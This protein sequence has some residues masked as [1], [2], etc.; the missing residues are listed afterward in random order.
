MGKLFLSML[1]TNKYEEAYYIYEGKKYG[2]VHFVQVATVSMNCSHWK[3][4]DR[5]IVFTTNEAKVKNWEDNGNQ[6]KGLK[7]FLEELNIKPSIQNIDIPNGESEDEIWQIFDAMYGAIKDKDEVVFDITHSFRSIPMLAMVVLN[8]AKVVKDVSIEGIYY[9]AFEKL[10]NLNTVRAKPLDERL[11]PIFNLTPF[12]ELLDWSL[13]LD[14]FMKTGDARAISNLAERT[15]RARLKKTAGE[16]HEARKTR[17]LAN[18]LKVF[19]ETMATCRGREIGQAA[20]NLKKAVDE[21]LS[22]ENI[23]APYIP[24]LKNLKDKLKGFAG[25]DIVVDGFQAALWCYEHNLIQQAYTILRETIL[26]KV[27]RDLGFNPED[28]SLRE[29]LSDALN[30]YGLRVVGKSNKEVEY[31]SEIDMLFEYLSYKKDLAVKY[32]DLAKY[33]NDID[34]A[35]M[36]RNVART[37]SIINNLSEFLRYFTK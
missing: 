16:D 23:K 14:R 12:E 20:K 22:L 11:V 36:G 33:R 5:I 32:M 34:H 2:P 9:G 35:G 18:T 24:L 7:S 28:K 17:Q 37:D 19:S 27:L 1:G 15:S 25:D 8:Y 10:G 3:E 26:S 21:C 30:N 31:C 29:K 4:N 13:G 6:P